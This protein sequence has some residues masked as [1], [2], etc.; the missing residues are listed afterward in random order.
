MLMG[1]CDLKYLC[2]F[3]DYDQV[4]RVEFESLVIARC[5]AL[6]ESIEQRKDQLLATVQEETVLKHHAFNDQ[7]AQYTTRM[8]STTGLLQFSIEVLKEQDPAAFLLVGV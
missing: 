5:A 1:S 2:I 8:H 7:M 4:N 6:V 3:D